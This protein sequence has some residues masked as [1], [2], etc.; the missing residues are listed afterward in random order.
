MVVTASRSATPLFDGAML[1]A[2]AFVAAVGSS[3]PDARELDDTALRRAAIVAVEWRQQALRE[4]GD[5]VLAE[6]SA[7]PPEKIVELGELVVGQA[8]GRRREADIT[9]FKSVG[10]GLADVAVAALAYRRIVSG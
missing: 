3:L 9:V 8:T 4:A 10:V 1:P 5:L 7:L 6:R 2:G